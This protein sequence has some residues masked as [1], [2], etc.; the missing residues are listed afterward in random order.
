MADAK[1]TVQVDIVLKEQRESQRQSGFS[2]AVSQVEQGKTKKRAMTETALAK[3]I[4]SVSR[5]SVT[6]IIGQTLLAVPQYVTSIAKALV[7]IV[8]GVLGAIFGVDM[9]SKMMSGGSSKSSSDIS[10]LGSTDTTNQMLLDMTSSVSAPSAPTE[11]QNSAGSGS[12]TSPT[13]SGPISADLNINLNTPTSASTSL[14]SPSD[15]STERDV[16]YKITTNMSPVSGV[17]TVKSTMTDIAQ[18]SK[19]PILEYDKALD[20]SVNT[21][22][23]KVNDI[24]DTYKNN[25]VPILDSVIGKLNTIHGLQVAL[26]QSTSQQN[27]SFNSTNASYT[28]SGGFDI[29]GNGYTGTDGQ[30]HYGSAPTEHVI[31]NNGTITRI[32]LTNQGG[33][34]SSKSN[35]K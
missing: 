32:P 35:P 8:P 31:Y 29:T 10:G 17:D 34:P 28:S 33:Q 5:L 20:Q 4:T 19:A 21:E 13:S 16:S 23:T 2:A 7:W 15:L 1:K 18:A 27:A 26:N 30:A 3:K 6:E 9:I 24:R 22:K 11:M 14:S 12:L 25:L